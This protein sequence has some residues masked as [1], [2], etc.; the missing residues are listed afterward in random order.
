MVAPRYR[1]PLSPYMKARRQ[2]THCGLH[3]RSPS[4]P[5]T[6]ARLLPR[7]PSSLEPWRPSCHSRAGTHAPLRAPTHPHL[8]PSCVGV[9]LLLP[10]SAAAS[11]PLLVC[12]N[13]HCPVSQ[14]PLSVSEGAPQSS[15]PQACRL[16]S[17]PSCSACPGCWL[18]NLTLLCWRT[19]AQ[20][21]G[22]ACHMPGA[23]QGA[24]ALA[25]P[26]PG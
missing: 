5:A 9:L 18:G 15:N 19:P 3:S 23:H 14:V 10:A 4:V 7:R 24:A 16:Q 26:A 6:A 21:A 13:A 12:T 17:T 20:A 25:A 1:Y 22:V 11:W 8:S 2:H